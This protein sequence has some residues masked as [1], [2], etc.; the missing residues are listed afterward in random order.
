MV[1]P[2]NVA[3]SEL[4]VASAAV[5]LMMKKSPLET[6]DAAPLVKATSLSKFAVLAPDAYLTI[7]LIVEL[8][9]VLVKV[10][11]AVLDACAVDKVIEPAATEAN[12]AFEVPRVAV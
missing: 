5:I 12:T 11:V 9:S 2:D 4:T 8:L 3:T 7:L 6:V 1:A 10:L